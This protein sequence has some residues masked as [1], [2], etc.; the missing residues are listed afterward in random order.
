MNDVSMLRSSLLRTS[1]ASARYARTRSPASMWP[2]GKGLW[3]PTGTAP[4]VVARLST[5]AG[6]ALADPAVRKRLADL[7]LE[8]PTVE[9]QGPEALHAYQATEIGN[10]GRSSGRP[11]SGASEPGGAILRQVLG[12]I[13]ALPTLGSGRPAFGYRRPDLRVGAG[14]RHL[15]L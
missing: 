10:G 5:A 7:A 12:R 8:I 3:A 13:Q 14:G 15:F 4:D 9:Q 6:E 1:S 2:F 11:G